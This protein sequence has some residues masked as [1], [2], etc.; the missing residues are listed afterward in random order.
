MGRVRT[1]QTVRFTVDA[2]PEETFTGTVSQVRLQPTVTQNVTTYASIID[3]ANPEMK[4]K[5]GMTANIRIEIARRTGVLRVPN[6]ALRF[7]P[8]EQIFA[9]LKMSQPSG[10]ARGALGRGTAATSTTGGT[11]GGQNGGGTRGTAGVQ[12]GGA[13]RASAGL[14]GGNGKSLWVYAD[15]R[16][17]PIPVRLGI[18]DG[19]M[20]ELVESPLEAGTLLVTDISLNTTASTTT[21]T[22]RRTTS[23]LVP[24]RPTGGPGGP[25]PM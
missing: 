18:S 6:A 14:Q 11:T 25:P 5:P 4:L 8:T 23:P 24:S 3:V 22:T 10:S 7:R 1:G 2:Y 19:T 12:P 16:L 21:T 17:T 9:A 20:T 15:G 13:T